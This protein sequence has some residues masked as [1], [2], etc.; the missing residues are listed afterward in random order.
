MALEDVFLFSKLLHS[1]GDC[2]ETALRAYEKKRKVRTQQA[3][4]TTQSNGA[5]RK[6]ISPWRLRAIELAASV[7]LWV[8]NVIG[9]GEMGFGQKELV[10]DVDEEEF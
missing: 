4:E 7:V 5:M 10:Y 9:L 6:K 1:D 8:H 2:I 3:L